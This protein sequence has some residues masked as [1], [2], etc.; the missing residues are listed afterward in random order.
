MKPVIVYLSMENTIEETIS[1][2]WAHCFGNDDN[3]ANHDRIEAARMLEQAG[4]FT[5]NDPYSPEL[6][7]W[8]RANR[9]INTAD[10]ENMLEDLKKENKQPVLL[11]LDYL[12]RIRAT[13]TNKDLRLELSNVTDELKNLAIAQDIPVL[14][15]HQLNRESF[16]TL[17]EAETFD[18]KVRASEK[19]NSSQI[20]DSI[21][22]IQNC[23]YGFILNRLQ[24]R[25]IND[26]GD[27]E[28]VDRFLYFKLIACRGK[29]PPIL[30]FRHR[31][32]KDNDMRLIEDINEPRSMSVLT[33]NEFI[34]ER[35][36]QS[37]QKTKG[38]RTII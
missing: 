37:G 12:K 35:T 29:Q 38:S 31:F 21:N 25:Q 8:Y 13:E 26:D 5:P 2:I 10:L 1:R 19:L 32:E 33:D 27:I 16:R 36:S 4:I 30:S 28:Y 3:I 34:K 20:G 11:V 15:A 9:S 23:D 22:I 17:E 6:L 24:K 7:I 18:E 14:T